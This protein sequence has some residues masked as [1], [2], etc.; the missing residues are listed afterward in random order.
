[1]NFFRQYFVPASA[2]L[3][4]GLVLFAASER[5]FVLAA[6]T[7]QVTARQQV[8]AE[9]SLTVASNALNM[10]PSIPSLSGGTGNATDLVT[11]ITN[12]STGYTVTMQASTGTVAAMNGETQGGYFTDYG[13]A[14]PQTWADTTAGQASQFG[15]GIT[16]GTLSSA[17]GASGYDT[18]AG[19]EAC[20]AKVPTT[21]PI[22]IVSVSSETAAEGDTFT[23][24]F[25][26]HIPANPNPLVPEDYYTATTTLTATAS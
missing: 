14:S 20:W 8:T 18:C 13:S 7:A 16:N 21:T 6:N 3:A 5:G 25:R 11:V 12:N 17:N 15:F 23:L 10:S 4:A 24:K 19:V 22:T 1:M 26:A 2:L 9:I